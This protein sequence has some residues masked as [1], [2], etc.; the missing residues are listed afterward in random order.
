MK[1]GELLNAVI[2]TVTD[3]EHCGISS[4]V[5]CYSCRPTRLPLA[6]PFTA[7]LFKKS[8]FLLINHLQFVWH[9]DDNLL[10]RATDHTP[11]KFMP[12]TIL[13]SLPSCE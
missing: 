7:V 8:Q 2:T 4:G 5:N 1:V 10:A 3:S 13:M 9:G 6:S 12:S 11:G